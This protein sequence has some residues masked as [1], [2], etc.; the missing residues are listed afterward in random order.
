[1]PPL[2]FLLADAGN[3]LPS[4]AKHLGLTLRTLQRYAAQ[5]C[6]PRTVMLAL[7][8]ESRWG[9]AAVTTQVQ[10]EAAHY[11]AMSKMAQ[12]QI[13]VLTAQIHALERERAIGEGLPANS[14]FFRP[15]AA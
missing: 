5:D 13:D 14:P 2:S 4:I 3:D 12:R 9:R 15:G 10:N 7:W 8:V 1:M 6:A 11:F